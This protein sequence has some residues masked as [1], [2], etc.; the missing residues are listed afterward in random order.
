MAML[1]DLLYQL[2]VIGDYAC[3]AVGGMR[4][5]RG[6]RNIRRTTGALLFCASETPRDMSW[7][8]TGTAAL[9]FR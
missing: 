3:G 5:S 4:I 9:G 8:L 1:T 7:A 2:Q 6:S